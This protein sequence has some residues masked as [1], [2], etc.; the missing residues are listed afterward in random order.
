MSTR[1]APR[2]DLDH[3]HA[4]LNRVPESRRHTAIDGGAHRGIWT[5]ELSRLFERV[6]A[7]EPH[8][9]HAEQ[10][11]GPD[12][13]EVYECALGS[14]VEEAALVT[15]TDNDGQYHLMPGE[16]TWIAP[17]DSFGL[18]NVDFIKLDVEGFEQPALEGGYT[19]IKESR[20]WVMIE[21]NGLAETRYGA[22][23]EGADKRLRQWGYR[24]VEKWNK[25]HLY[26]P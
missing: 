1:L 9:G 12:N 5:R 11:E 21:R 6:V 7:F 20:P 10:I 19:T 16:G 17:L 26:A 22:D 8:P 4:A 13:V 23:P 2:H 24:H 14:S 18:R 25:D 3:L 15:D